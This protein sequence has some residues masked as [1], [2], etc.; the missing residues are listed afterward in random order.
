MPQ[1]VSDTGLFCCIRADIGYTMPLLPM[2]RLPALAALAASLALAIALRAAIPFPQAESD[3]RTDP[4]A[5]FGT[6]PSGMRYVVVPNHEPKGRVSL[7]LLV[8]AGSFNETEAQRGLAHYLEHMAFNGSTHFAPGTLVETLQRLGMGFG[9]DTNA[10][11]S[12]DHTLY[13]LELPDTAPATVSEGLQILE[14]YSGGLLLEQKMVDKERGIILSEKRSR[15]SVDYRTMVAQMGFMDAGTRIPERLPI[16][17]TEIIEKSNRDPFVD[18]YNTWY[19]PE[20][21]VVIVVGD[22]D[23]PAIQKQIVDG[24]SGIAA[25]SPEPAPADLGRVTEFTGVKTL[26]HPEPEAPETRVVIAS[27]TPYAHEADNS[28]NRIKYLPRDLAVD[29]LNHRLEI[30]AKK[31]NAPF[32]EAGSNVEDS[33]DLIRTADIEVTCKADQWT[34]AM[35]VADTELRRALAFGFR[36]DE[37]KEAVADFRNNVEQAVKSASTRRSDVLA[38]DIAESLVDRNVF[39]SPADDLALY[40]PALDKVTAAQCVDALKTSWASPGRYVFV[41]GNAKVAG[42]ANAVVSGAYARAETVD[43]TATDA[44]AAVAWGYGDF[45]AAGAIATRSH[46]DDLDITQVTFANGVRLN[47]KRTDFEAD[48]IH[49]ASRLGTGQLTEPPSERGLNSFGKLTLSA[50][51]LGKHSVDELERILAGKTVGLSFSSTSDA[52]LLGGQTNRQDLALELQLLTA[53]IEDPGYRPEAMRVGRKRIAEAYLSF[54]HT[55]NGPLALHVQNLLANGDPRFG[56]P[57]KDEMSSRSLDE[58]KAWLAPQF[59]NG[60]LEVSLVG[61]F[62]VETA[63]AAAART[64]GTLPARAAK[65]ALDDLRKVSFPAQPFVDDYAID[66]AIPKALVATYYPTADGVDIQRARRL[67]IL[68]EIFSDRLRVKIREQMGSTYAPSVGSSASDVFP[69]YGYIAALVELDPAKA[70]QI[71][72]VVIAVAADL[73][74]NGASQDELDRAKN[75]ILTSIRETERTNKYWL[76]VL[77]RCQEKPQVLDWARSRSTDYAAISKADVDA[78]AKSYLAPEKASRVIIHPYP[79]PAA[80]SMMRPTPTPSPPPDGM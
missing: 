33:F 47:L 66:S 49:V 75:P 71:Q 50:G 10:S 12:F 1:Q 29:M 40:G 55:L 34:A 15:D 19:R 31:E 65:P 62:D 37:L 46:V 4:I 54:E 16:G 42:D 69:G 17:L 39:T 35:T 57:S 73:A 80:S 48:T 13:Q 68:A 26:F 52:F 28:A 59:A 18:F 38:R 45:G 64:I 70:K 41:A 51:G 24:F 27:C 58:L 67:G 61:D 6:L 9:A 3:L 53:S 72:V 76:T 21:I 14:D 43:V 23:G 5:T 2:R 11:T 30:L 36:P 44:Q 20:N 77:G 32:I 22:I 79:I 7:R 56:L 74:A 25:R 78:L 63:I 60:A 8:L